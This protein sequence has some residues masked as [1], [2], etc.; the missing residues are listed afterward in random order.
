MSLVR[1]QDKATDTERHVD[2]T[3]SEDEEIITS[4]GK[5]QHGLESQIVSP[6]ILGWKVPCPH[7][8]ESFTVKYIHNGSY[9]LSVES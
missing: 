8:G 3:S 2:A 1:K 9:E 7:C 5:R 6:S 4:P